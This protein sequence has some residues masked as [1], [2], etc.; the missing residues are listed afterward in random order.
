MLATGYSVVACL[1]GSEG[2]AGPRIDT[3]GDRFAILRTLKAMPAVGD[4]PVIVFSG[5]PWDAD[6]GQ[7]YALGACLYLSKP[8]D[9]EEHL[10]IG[11]VIAA[12]RRRWTGAPVACAVAC[13]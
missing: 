7:A 12:M 13:Q 2:R 11:F 9:V 6:A 3:H 4:M 1:C 10:R 5:S 8:W